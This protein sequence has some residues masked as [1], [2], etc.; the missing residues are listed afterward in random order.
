MK[1]LVFYVCGHYK[2]FEILLFVIL[3][4]QMKIK[5]CLNF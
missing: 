2:D 1:Y 3:M 4:Y 5:K